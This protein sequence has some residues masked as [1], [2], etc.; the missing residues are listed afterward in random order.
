MEGVRS[1]NLLRSTFLFLAP[2]V[3]W[4]EQIRPKDEIEVRFLSGAPDRGDGI[5][6]REKSCYDAGSFVLQLLY[7]IIAA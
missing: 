5:D 4:T 7:V 1:S 2:V 3:Q 6:M